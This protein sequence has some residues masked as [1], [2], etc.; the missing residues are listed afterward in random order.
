MMLIEFARTWGIA[1]VC[2]GVAGFL[3]VITGVIGRAVAPW[4]PRNA[5]V[6]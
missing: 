2:T 1:I 5:A 4:A 3:Y 6:D